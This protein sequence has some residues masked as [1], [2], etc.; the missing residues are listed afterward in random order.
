MGC[1][2][3]H[4]RSE[5]AVKPTLAFHIYGE[6]A[7]AS[8]GALFHSGQWRPCHINHVHFDT[9]PVL[10]VSQLRNLGTEVPVRTTSQGHRGL[11]FLLVLFTRNPA[12][13][14]SSRVSA[15]VK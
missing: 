8:A 12:A 13:L 2:D 1:C 5:E 3:Q 9:M 4:V 10:G 7:S 6:G 11:S 14:V 15:P